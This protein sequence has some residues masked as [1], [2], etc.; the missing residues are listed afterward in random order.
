MDRRLLTPRWILTTILVLAAIGVMIR[1]GFWQLDRLQQRRAANARIQAQIDAP[2]LDLNQQI[3][4][5][6]DLYAMEYRQVIVR[7]TFDSQNEVILRGQA[8]E[9]MPGHH[10]LTPLRMEGS[11]QAVLVDRGFIPLNDE[12]PEAREKYAVSGPVEVRAVIRRS[13]SARRF[14]V[15]D[16]T[17]AP[18]QVRLDAWNAVR[19]DRIAGQID[20]P[21][22]PVY[23]EA[24]PVAGQDG[25]PYSQV[26]APDLS[27]GPHM[28]YAFQWFSFATILAVGYP[29]F[30]R[31]QLEL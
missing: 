13:Q 30:V 18:G 22:L 14:G 12:K 31:K 20:Y 7:G 23:L 27:E 6:D 3:P 28:G 26:E 11:D 16:P 5:A 21:I 2:P 4:T 10:L 29:F 15:P 8:R 19:L 1:L 17:L 25:P 24:L 9:G